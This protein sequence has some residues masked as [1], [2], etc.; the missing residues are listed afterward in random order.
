MHRLFPLLL[1][2][3]IAAPLH[4]DVLKI[5]TLHIEDAVPLFLAEREGF[6]REAGVP[7]E[8]VPFQSAL[9]R[10]SALTAGAIDGAITDPVGALLLDQGRGLLRLTALCLGATPAEGPFAILAAPNSPLRTVDDLKGVEVAVSRATIIDYVTDRLLAGHGFTPA[11]R[12]TIDIKKM[13]IRLQMLLGSQV[14]AATLPEPL[15]AI[16]MGRGARLLVSDADSTTSLSQTVFVFRRP[17]LAE[18][19]GEVAAFFAALGRAVRLINTEP[20]R[21]RPL[22]VDK[23]R[24]PADLSATYPIP[25]YPE[26]APFP[27]ELYAPVIDWL[28]ERRLSPP[29]AYEQLVDRDFLA[30]DE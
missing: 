17:V 8:L 29:L 16:A 4:A 12:R 23:G 19:K 22:F 10:D 20:E 14:Q 7:V 18:R 24:I 28:A 2:V 5:G 3:L 9:E 30:R 1:L 13:P 6:F 21:Y 27:R 25:A 11:E 15:A 26:P